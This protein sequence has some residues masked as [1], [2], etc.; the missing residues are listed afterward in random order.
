[1][2]NEILASPIIQLL[3]LLAASLLVRYLFL[4]PS[5]LPTAAGAPVMAVGIF[6]VGALQKI[7]GPMHIFTQ[8]LGLELLVIWAYIAWGL[9][10]SHLRGTLHVHADNPVGRFA[11]GTWVA[12]TSTMG[13]VLYLALPDWSVP[14][15]ALGLIMALLWVWY[16]ALIVPG[17]RHLLTNR[18]KLPITGRILLATVGTQSLVVFWAAVYPG[19]VSIW[20]ARALIGLG[21]LFYFLGFVL[22]VR[23]YMGQRGWSL[24]DDWD[25]TNCILHGAMS[26]TGN[27]AVRSGA[28]PTEWIILIWLWTACIFLLV[29]FIEI[30]RLVTRVAQYGW[31]DGVFTYN[32][33]QWARNF[34]FGM[35]YVFTFLLHSHI[36]NSPQTGLPWLVPVQ[37]AII[38]WGP[39]VVLFFLAVEL[40][41]F[42]LCNARLRLRIRS[43]HAL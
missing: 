41:I 38:S 25:N 19:S 22:I 3:I 14:I 27:A 30:A 43:E 31:R 11:I 4:R 7:P 8:L 39:Y 29:E 32:V 42:V 12:A 20:L 2:D 5:E 37:N 13:T 36:G 26:I 15:A 10:S 1:M 18:N 23:R 35:F 17:F 9:I 16:I 24:A 21:M 6:T 33:S 28:L 34:T 40:A